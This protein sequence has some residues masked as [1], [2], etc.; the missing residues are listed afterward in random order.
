MMIE[1]GSMFCPPVFF[2]YSIERNKSEFEIKLDSTD[3]GK[4]G[5]YIKM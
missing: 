5:L 3:W 2:C 4:M 1:I